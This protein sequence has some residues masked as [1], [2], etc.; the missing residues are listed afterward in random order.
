LSTETNRIFAERYR[1]EAR[2]VALRHTDPKTG[3]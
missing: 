3:P 1:A 2:L